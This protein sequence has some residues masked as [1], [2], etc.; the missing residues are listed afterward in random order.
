DGRGTVDLDALRAALKTPT[1]LVAIT[2]A[3][4][5]TGVVQPVEEIGRLA[6]EA[7]ALVL[8]DAAQTAG[9]LPISLKE[10]P[11]DLI[12][13]PGHKGLLGPLGTGLLILREGIERQLQPLR[14][15]GT[16]TVSESDLQPEGL[17]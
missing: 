16:G 9:H 4:N 11:V 5:V 8:L 2:H 6:H 12:A 14:Q 10:W 17:P 13:C 3:S 1:R 15:G 7:G